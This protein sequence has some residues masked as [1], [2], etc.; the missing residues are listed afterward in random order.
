MLCTTYL[1]G[2]CRTLDLVLRYSPISAFARQKTQSQPCSLLPFCGYRTLWIG[3]L[4]HYELIVYLNVYAG[5]VMLQSRLASK[6]IDAS[7]ALCSIHRICLT[8]RLRRALLER[9]VEGRLAEPVPPLVVLAHAISYT[10]SAN[11][12]VVCARLC[13]DGGATKLSHMALFLGMRQYRGIMYR[14]VGLYR[15]TFRCLVP[16]AST[17]RKRLCSRPDQTASTGLFDVGAR[18]RHLGGWR[19]RSSP[20]CTS[21]SQLLAPLLVFGGFRNPPCATDTKFRNT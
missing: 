2:S 12:V 8:A 19:R 13:L 4:D 17:G 1:R 9:W 6:L 5:A 11:R 3:T 10:A 20:V 14:Y 21:P 15:S 18:S 16:S 7:I